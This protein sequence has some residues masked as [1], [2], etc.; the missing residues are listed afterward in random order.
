MGT[1]KGHKSRACHPVRANN[2]GARAR[3]KGADDYPVTRHPN[4]CWTLPNKPRP[5]GYVLLGRKSTRRVFAHR[6][7]FEHMR[8][9]I[10]AGLTLDHLCRN[11]ACVNPWHL[12]PV[13][14]RENILRGGGPAAEG[15]RRTRCRLGHELVRLAS[16]KRGCPICRRTAS[17]KHRERTRLRAVGAQ[18]DQDAR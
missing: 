15:A 10:P 13:S 7:F 8:G 18:E 17:E 14:I 16:G 3:A 5:D 6:L 4:D 12:E 2:L 9:P 1:P 11:R